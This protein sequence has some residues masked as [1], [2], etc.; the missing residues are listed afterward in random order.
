MKAIQ[1]ADTVQILCWTSENWAGL[2]DQP[3][4]PSPKPARSNER[5]AKIQRE[6]SNE[7]GNGESQIITEAFIKARVGLRQ[8][9]DAVKQVTLESLWPH[10]Q[11]LFLYL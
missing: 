4:E 11:M 2:T 7:K 10:Q 3:A 6:R 1:K 5:P 8:F 9:R